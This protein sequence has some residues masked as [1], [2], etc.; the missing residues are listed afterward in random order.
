MVK[1]ERSGTFTV[2]PA[3]A[4]ISLRHAVRSGPETPAFGVPAKYHFAGCPFAGVT[5]ETSS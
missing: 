3:K 4:G 5:R 2:I 1:G